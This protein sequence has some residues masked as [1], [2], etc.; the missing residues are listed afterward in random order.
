MEHRHIDVAQKRL[1]TV[2]FDTEAL[3]CVADDLADKGIAGIAQAVYALTNEH[4][5]VH[6]HKRLVKMVDKPLYGHCVLSRTVVAFVDRTCLFV[7]KPCQVSVEVD[8]LPMCIVYHLYFGRGV[9]RY[10]ERTQ[11]AV[12]KDNYPC[13]RV[14]LQ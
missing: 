11:V 6:Q 12:V 9:I 5:G 14:M 2:Y 4:I 10:A 8:K 13:R 7:R 1:G 3:A